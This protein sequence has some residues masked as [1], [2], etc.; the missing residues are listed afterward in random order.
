MLLHQLEDLLI[1]LANGLALTSFLWKVSLYK[2]P[3]ED[4]LH[5]WDPKGLSSE[6]TV[7]STHFPAGIQKGW[8]TQQMQDHFTRNVSQSELPSSTQRQWKHLQEIQKGFLVKNVAGGWRQRSGRV[9]ALA[10]GGDNV[11]KLAKSGAQCVVHLS[12]GF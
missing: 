10:P 4:V 1:H 6:C 7:S 11:T 3:R 9:F 5:G 2:Q 8:W 12:E